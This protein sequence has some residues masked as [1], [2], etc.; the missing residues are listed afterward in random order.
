MISGCFV[1]IP[2]YILYILSMFPVFF[3][4]LSWFCYFSSSCFFYSWLNCFACFLWPSF[5]PTFHLISMVIFFCLTSYPHCYFSLSSYYP[6]PYAWVRSRSL[7][8]LSP[9]VSL[10]RRLQKS[11]CIHHDFT[12]VCPGEYPVLCSVYHHYTVRIL[13]RFVIKHY[14]RK[15]ASYPY[16]YRILWYLQFIWYGCAI[17]FY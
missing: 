16:L 1:Y 7:V 3:T 15:T 12:L 14:F 4:S 8:T 13:L 5:F 6:T 9:R 10:A 11:M 17:T 2:C